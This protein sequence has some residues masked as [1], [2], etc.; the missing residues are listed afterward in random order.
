MF[1]NNTSYHEPLLQHEQGCICSAVAAYCN[2]PG[3]AF[4]GVVSQRADKQRSI[5]YYSLILINIQLKQGL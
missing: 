1:F 2:V 5:E 4:R 3:T